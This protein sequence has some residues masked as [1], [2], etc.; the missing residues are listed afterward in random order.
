MTIY[1]LIYNGVASTGET[2][3]D[4]H[5]NIPQQFKSLHHIRLKGKLNIPG[6]CPNPW[7][8][9]YYGGTTITSSSGSFENLAFKNARKENVSGLTTCVIQ[10]EM[11]FL[12]LPKVFRIFKFGLKFSI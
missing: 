9:A 3:R 2:E 12:D 11:D 1:L 4:P 7:A 5:Q 6:E 10:S 8:S